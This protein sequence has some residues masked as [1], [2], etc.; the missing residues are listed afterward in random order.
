MTPE[1]DFIKTGHISSNGCDSENNRGIGMACKSTVVID[2][3]FSNRIPYVV[4]QEL[5]T[6]NSKLAR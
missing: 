4:D 1:F 3:V 5:D 2:A 6:E